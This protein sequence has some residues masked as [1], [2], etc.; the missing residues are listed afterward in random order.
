VP[1]CPE[2]NKKLSCA[3]HAVKVGTVAVETPVGIG[4]RLKS[5]NGDLEKLALAV[6]G[7]KR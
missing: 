1:S 2:H 5:W 3:C 6:Q 7:K 4:D